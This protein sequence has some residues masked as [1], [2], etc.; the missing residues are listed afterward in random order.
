[1]RKPS[2]KFI[3]IMNVVANVPM[4]V[5]M[6]VTA[7]LL[8][9]MPV[10]S[11][12]VC[13]N[14]LIGFVLACLIN[15]LLPIQKMSRAVPEKMK[16]DSESIPGRI[17]GNIIPC[18]IFTGVIGLIMSFYN[19]RQAPAF[20]FAFIETAVPM[21]IVC[22]AVSMIFVPLAIKTAMTA[23]ISSRRK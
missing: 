16:L 5:A 13:I 1:M 7:P 12:N 4:A 6:S 17:V 9:G 15:L 3:V 11:V 21:Y 14:I 20:V 8:V 2:V 22:F 10:F 23:E 18:L 19:V